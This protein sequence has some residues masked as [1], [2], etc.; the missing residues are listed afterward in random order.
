MNFLRTS[1][2]ASLSTGVTMLCGLVTTKYV[3]V[4][5]GPSGMALV[6][7]FSNVTVMLSLFATAAC[8]TGV[9]KYVAQY[10]DVAQKQKVIANALLL[11]AACS[12]VVSLVCLLFSGMLSQ[13]VFNENG[14]RVVFVV[15]GLLVFFPSFNAI[16]SSVLNGL[17]KIRLMSLI[18]IGTSVINLTCVLLAAR[19]FGIKG[20]L[21]ANLVGGVFS[22]VAYLML[23]RRSNM[24]PDHIRPADWDT[25]VVKALVG[26]SV[27]ALTTGL[28]VPT[29]QLIIR[30]KL[31]YNLGSHNAGIWQ[32]NT[33][34]SDY[35]LQF[36]NTVLGIYYLPRLSELKE[37]SELR[38]EVLLGFKRIMPAV[39]VVTS[40]IWIF[41][42]WTIDILLTKQ[43]TGM[44]TLL[45]WQ[46]IGDVV[47][48]ASWLLGYLM[49]ARAM[50]K[51]FV[52]TEIIF[53]TTYVLL[54]ILFV[55][56]F[57]LVGSVYAF[58]LNYVIYFVTLSLLLRKTLT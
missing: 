54:T 41:R 50:K 49:V 45:K 36:F 11:V 39:I 4:M 44:L 10:D 17:K 15:Y 30:T 19:F 6:G 1:F 21:L 35:Y 25:T 38:H 47:R 58:C 56:Q 13:R 42:Q 7:Q 16:I 32:A 46:L 57:G 52:A 9:V 51:L 31:L 12:V 34:L 40:L 28:V 22:F 8:A 29:I 53:S 14:Y 20:I 2:W 18:A 23:F 55:N 33:R 24:F 26:Y 37:K 27:M 5:I 3:A 43:F 48:I